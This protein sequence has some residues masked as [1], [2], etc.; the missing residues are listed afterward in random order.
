MN[1][2]AAAQLIVDRERARKDK[3]A[4][5]RVTREIVKS[6]R[7]MAEMLE[8]GEIA[9][10]SIERNFGYAPLF[11][12]SNYPLSL[13]RCERDDELTLKFRYPFSRFAKRLRR[14]KR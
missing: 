8:T 9:E 13:G 14:R 5:R 6:L 11:G 10:W 7:L 12:K 2:L 3:L 4:K 1:K